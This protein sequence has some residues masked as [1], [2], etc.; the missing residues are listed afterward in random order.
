MEKIFGPSDEENVLVKI[1]SLQ[2][3]FSN[4]MQQFKW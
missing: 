1:T 2:K 4:E 3:K